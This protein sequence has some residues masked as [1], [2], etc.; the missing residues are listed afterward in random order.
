[1]IERI[2]HGIKRSLFGATSHFAIRQGSC[3]F[4]GKSFVEIYRERVEYPV[5]ILGIQFVGQKQCLGEYRILAD[6]QEIFPFAETNPIE[7]GVL[8]NF[9][10]P[11]R[12]AAGALLTIDVRSSNPQERG[13]IIMDE[14]D[15]VEMR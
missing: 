8:R 5:E 11:I 2:Y 1:M 15:I 6:G 9:V 10:V 4:Q 3:A 13:V 12:V 14:L 7:V